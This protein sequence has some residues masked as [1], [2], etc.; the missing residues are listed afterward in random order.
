VTKDAEGS[1]CQCAVPPFDFRNFTRIPLGDDAHGGEIS[2]A[3]C[4]TCGQLW[5][6]YLIEW[7]HYTKSSRWWRVALSAEQRDALDTENARAFIEQQAAG[8][9]GGCIFDGTVRRIQAPIKIF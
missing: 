7:P 6:S 8:F 3:T 9:V 4:R 2:I 1:N 5:L